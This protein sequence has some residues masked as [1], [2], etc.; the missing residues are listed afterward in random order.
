MHARMLLP[1]LAVLVWPGWAETPSKAWT[2]NPATP[3]GSLNWGQVAPDFGTCGATSDGHFVEVGMKQTPVDIVTANT[4]KTTLAALSFQYRETPFVVE[5]TGH[6][7]EVP[8]AAGSTIRFGQL[9]PSALDSANWPQAT[10]EFRLV[11]FHFHAPSEHTID[12]KR[13]DMEL[14]LVHMNQLGD[15]AVVGVLLSS[16]TAGN[17]LFDKIMRLAPSEEGHHSLPGAT[18]NAHQLLPENLSY[19]MYSGS[20]TTPP[21]TEGV[22]WVVLR[23]PVAISAYAIQQMHKLVSQFPEYKGFPDNNRLV[24]P[25]HGRPVLVDR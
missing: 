6:V 11:Q 13:F 2:H 7:I 5:N 10:E 12:G 17:P 20:L 21:C 15:L 8:Y 4:T 19:Y 3:I 18:I 14:H 16:S 1:V 9:V 25:L 22:R 23:N 24:L